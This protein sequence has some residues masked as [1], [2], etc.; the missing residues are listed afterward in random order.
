[1]TD[2]MKHYVAGMLI[3]LAVGLPCYLDSGS[4]F[5]G[6]WAAMMGGIVA[7]AVK[8]YTDNAHDGC[9]DWID[10]LCTATGALFAALFIVL[11]HYGK[12]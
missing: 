8:E 12:G 7:G 6:L 1:M 5:A 9:W 11:L 10:L 4:L 2:R 3:A